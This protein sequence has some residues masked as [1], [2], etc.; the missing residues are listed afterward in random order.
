MQVDAQAVID[1]LTAQIGRLAGELAVARAQVKALQ[2][3]SQAVGQ[4]AP[5]E[6][7]GEA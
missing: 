5:A 3:A 7:V 2:A 1:E 6:G 4:A